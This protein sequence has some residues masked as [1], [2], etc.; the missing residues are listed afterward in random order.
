M[1]LK[2]KTF[3]KAYIVIQISHIDLQG[4]KYPMYL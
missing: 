1:F 4:T 3:R 2:P